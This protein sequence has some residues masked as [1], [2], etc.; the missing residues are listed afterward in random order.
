MASCCALSRPS[1]PLASCACAH[2]TKPWAISTCCRVASMR[3]CRPSSY[4]DTCW[5][6]SSPSKGKVNVNEMISALAE[7]RIRRNRR[8]PGAHTPWWEKNPSTS[9]SGGSKAAVGAV[10]AETT[11]DMFELLSV[12]CC[13][14]TCRRCVVPTISVALKHGAFQVSASP[15]GYLSALAAGWPSQSAALRADPAAVATRLQGVACGVVDGPRQGVVQLAGVG[16]ADQVEQLCPPRCHR[17]RR[18]DAAEQWR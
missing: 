18:Q 8:T 5:L 1:A 15:G 2:T 14:R 7:K 6:P 17:T 4:C 12:R 16:D 10:V 3:A 11:L 9:A 13:F